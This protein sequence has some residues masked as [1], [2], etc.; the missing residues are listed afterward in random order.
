MRRSI[1]LT[2]GGPAAVVAGV[3]ALAACSADTADFQEQGANFLEGDEV[4]ER[5]GMVRMSDA[6]CEEPVD[7]NKDT[8]YTCTASGSDGHTWGFTIEI[9]GSKSLRVID[10]AVVSQGTTPALE[11]STTPGPTTVVPAT[12]VPTTTPGPT[13]AAPAPAATTATTTT[14]TP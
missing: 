14:T 3:L 11:T 12:V 13:T 7:T 10:G 8:L 5:F 6:E 1:P 2:A 9:T 4:R